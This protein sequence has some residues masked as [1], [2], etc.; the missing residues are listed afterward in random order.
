MPRAASSVRATAANACCS[1]ARPSASGPVEAP[2][3]G[4]LGQPVGHQRARRQ[5]ARPD[6]RPVEHLV[7]CRHPVDQP[8]GERLGGADLA[9]REDHL[10][11]PGRADEPG[12]PLGAAPTGD[13]PEQHFGQ[14][15]P[16]VLGADPEV[17]GQRQL[18]PASQ[19]VAVDGG[20]GGPGQTGQGPERAGEVRPH[21]AGVGAIELDDVGT[22]G[23]DPPAAPQHHRAGRVGGQALG[24]G[25]DL[26]E[27][28]AGEGVGLGPVQPDQGDAVVASLEDHEGVG[29]QA[30]PYLTGRPATTHP[31]RR[32]SAA[33]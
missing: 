33:S 26:P 4:R 25:E 8:D 30:A 18:Q 9:P 24:D 12:Q 20:D 14:A 15:Q 21:G 10:L 27:H 29:H 13:H 7:G 31:A 16:G 5:L 11:G 17:A 28:R 2:V 32:R 19:R 1:R 6:Q 22:G 23:K 3:D